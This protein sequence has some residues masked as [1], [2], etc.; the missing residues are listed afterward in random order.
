MHKFNVNAT[1]R[2]MLEGYTIMERGFNETKDEAKVF[3]RCLIIVGSKP[4]D[5]IFIQIK[6]FR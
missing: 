4:L 1:G 5:S 2:K 3:K 6:E